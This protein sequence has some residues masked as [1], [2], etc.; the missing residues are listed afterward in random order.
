MNLWRLGRILILFTM[1]SSASWRIA[2]A[3]DSFEPNDTPA[4]AHTLTNGQAIESWISTADDID[5]YK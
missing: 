2:L 5:W 1:V 3:A 4:Q